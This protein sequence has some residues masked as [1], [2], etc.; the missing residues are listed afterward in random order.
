MLI[1]GLRTILVTAGGAGSVVAMLGD[2]AYR[3]PQGY[4][5]ESHG[6]GEGCLTE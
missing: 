1:V 3:K 5:G 2:L 4:S 6:V